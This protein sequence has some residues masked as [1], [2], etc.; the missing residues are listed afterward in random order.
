LCLC[1]NA[2]VSQAD[3]AKAIRF[4]AQRQDIQNFDIGFNR[5][6]KAISSD[7]F[8]RFQSVHTSVSTDVNNHVVHVQELLQVCQL[9][10]KRIAPNVNSPAPISCAIFPL[11]DRSIGKDTLEQPGSRGQCYPGFFANSITFMTAPRFPAP[12]G[13]FEV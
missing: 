13:H 3:I 2:Q 10:L 1:S 9:R 4:N 12:F 11:D 5:N 8:G 7:L 6:D